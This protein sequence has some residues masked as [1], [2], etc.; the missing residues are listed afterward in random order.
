MNRTPARIAY[1]IGLFALTACAVIPAPAPP[2]ITATPVVSVQ[3]TEARL[4]AA[5]RERIDIEASG[6]IH[7]IRLDDLAGEIAELRRVAFEDDAQGAR[8]ELIDALA[9][10]LSAVMARRTHL[11]EHFGA[12]HPQADV[13]AQVIRGLTAAINAE[14][15]RSGV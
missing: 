2:V 7:D 6:A 1:C 15:R 12:R 5:I 10:E 8:I 13:N 14:V 9:D 11:S 4:A 3:S